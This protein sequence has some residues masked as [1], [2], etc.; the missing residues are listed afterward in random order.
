MAKDLKLKPLAG[1]ILVEAIEEEE[2]LSIIIPDSAKEDTKPQKG[3][4]VALGT[5]RILDDGTKQEFNV[6]V[7]DVVFFKQYAPDEVKVM[8][9]KEEKTYLI[10]EESDVLAII[11]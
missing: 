9:G 10:M 4:V 8:E 6:K 11:S 2:S 5:G 7:G 1:R 3:R